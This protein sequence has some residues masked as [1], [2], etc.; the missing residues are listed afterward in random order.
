MKIIDLLNMIANGVN[1]PIEINYK[2][3]T[4]RYDCDTKD[5]YSGL[6]DEYLLDSY[7][8]PTIL[9]DEVEILEITITNKQDDKIEKIV[10]GNSWWGNS[11]T[12]NE[13]TL[14]M[15]INEIIDKVNKL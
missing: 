11:A 6:N 9:N 5:Y 2:D 4:Y 3:I 10:E 8:I 15:K 14:K 12:G 7:S 13:A 1:I